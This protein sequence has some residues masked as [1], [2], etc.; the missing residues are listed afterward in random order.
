[1]R[2]YTIVVTEAAACNRAIRLG[3]SGRVRRR[4]RRDAKVR[5]VDPKLGKRHS[6]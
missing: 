4:T 2:S 5:G 3:I 1:M 6:P